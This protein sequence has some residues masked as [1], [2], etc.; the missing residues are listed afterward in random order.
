M[1][2]VYLLIT[3]SVL[4]Y[5]ACDKSTDTTSKQANEFSLSIKDHSYRLTAFY[6]NK[7]IDYY[8]EDN[9]SSSDSDLWKFTKTYLWDD[10][11]IFTGDSILKIVQNSGQI[12]GTTDDTLY[13]SYKVYA[14]DGRVRFSFIDYYYKPLEYRVDSFNDKYFIIDVDGPQNS[15]L[16]SRFDRLN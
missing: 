11:N 12:P 15:I 16:Y 9:V 7:F 14:S 5:V 2:L 4:G 1:K 13:R 3:V 10:E 6:A 8:P